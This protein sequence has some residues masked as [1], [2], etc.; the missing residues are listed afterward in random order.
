[1]LVLENLK[2]QAFPNSTLYEQEVKLLVEV[3]NRFTEKYPESAR[4]ELRGSFKLVGRHRGDAPKEIMSFDFPGGV[5]IGH[6]ERASFELVDHLI[7]HA[8]DI[9]DFAIYEPIK[10]DTNTLCI[11]TKYGCFIMAVAMVPRDLSYS[12]LLQMAVAL[13][14]LGYA[15]NSL[16]R[17]L[18]F[19]VDSLHVSR[20]NRDEM[21]RLEME[22]IGNYFSTETMKEWLKWHRLHFRTKG[23]KE[24]GFFF[25]EDE[26]SNQPAELLR[27]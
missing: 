3:A 7:G 24:L 14:Q 21:F 25:E 10:R 27:A 15:P 4:K 22:L 19:S 16:D 18:A 12:F 23:D 9:R 1:M 2:T 11:K 17:S 8:I 5:S 20:E 26:K 6:N 13:K